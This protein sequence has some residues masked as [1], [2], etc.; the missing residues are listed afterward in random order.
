MHPPLR[1]EVPDAEHAT[2]L[3]RHLQPFGFE[4][5]AV[6]G[7]Y[8]VC[9]ELIARNPD[10]RITAVLNAVDLWLLTAAVPF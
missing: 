4:T 1:I 5:V 9:V 3:R 10:R 2:T 6:N 7:H 8:E